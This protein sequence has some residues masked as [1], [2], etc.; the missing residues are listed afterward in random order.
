MK[1]LK[2]FCFFILVIPVCALAKGDGGI[3]LRFVF[4]QIFNFSLFVVALLYLI[5][6]YLPSF[7]QRK[8]E[9]FLEYRRKARELEKQHEQDFISLEKEVRLLAEKEKNI[10]ESVTKALN[11]L[12]RELEAQEKQW[13]ESVQR[14]ADKEIKLQRFTELN[15]LKNRFLSQVMQQT[16]KQLKKGQAERPVYKLSQVIQ[17]WEDM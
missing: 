16:K 10:E 4:F 6:K 5:R 9:D 17:Q 3:P 15:H 11:N 12:K 1:I 2:A 8:R 13:L 7:L 14:Q